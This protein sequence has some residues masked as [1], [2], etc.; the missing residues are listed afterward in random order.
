MLGQ[1]H[2]NFDALNIGIIAIFSILQTKYGNPYLGE[3]IDS[4]KNYPYI[5]LFRQQ[6]AIA[7]DHM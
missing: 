3:S 7:L 1:S 4:M 5:R 6:D 2:L